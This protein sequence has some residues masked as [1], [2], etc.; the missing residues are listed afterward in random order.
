MLN[1]ICLNKLKIKYGKMINSKQV[2]KSKFKLP[3]V[4]VKNWMVNLYM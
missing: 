2:L 3:I 4:I 1:Y